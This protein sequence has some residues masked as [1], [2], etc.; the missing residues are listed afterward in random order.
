MR[1]W[2]HCQLGARVLAWSFTLVVAAGCG[3][4][5]YPGQPGVVTNSYS[6][7]DLE[8]L[9]E[10]GLFYYEAIYDN[11]PGGAGVGALITKLYPGATTYTSNV[12]TNADGTVYRVKGQY[13]AGLV[14]MISIPSVNQVH[15]S[16][17][18][19][20]LFLVSYDQSLDEVDDR[21]IAEEQIFSPERILDLVWPGLERLRQKLEF[22][23]SGS[24]L[25][26]GN[27][28]YE[29]VS[30]SLGDKVFRPSKSVSFETNFGQNA[31]HS[32]C[33]AALRNEARGFLESN[34]PKGYHGTVLVELASGVKL[35]LSLGLDT[36][37][38]LKASGKQVIPNASEALAKEVAL[39]FKGTAHE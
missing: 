28:S 27:L 14:Q 15:I 13:D 39:K 2:Q 20:V 31:L 19:K 1:F 17:Q 12:R 24:L 21:N 11:R 23:K 8:Y 38:T 22:L 5:E 37:D 26:S 3:V 29:V 10:E 34:F 4:V 33:N 30:L 16:P 36:I 35:P 7:I 9:E 25:P 6:K 18:S 32:N